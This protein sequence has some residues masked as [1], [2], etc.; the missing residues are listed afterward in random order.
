MVWTCKDGYRYS[1]S[2]ETLIIKKMF[3]IFHY[4]LILSLQMVM[5]W[6]VHKE[7]EMI[8]ASMIIKFVKRFCEEM[9]EVD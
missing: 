7:N 4:Y 3:K 6:N 2:D 8:G 1:H 9:I 5:Y